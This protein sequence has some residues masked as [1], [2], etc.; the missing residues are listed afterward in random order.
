MDKE[1]ENTILK[2]IEQTRTWRKSYI[3]AFRTGLDHEVR[4]K[5]EARVTEAEINFKKSQIEREKISAEARTQREKFIT[6][7][8]QKV[9][10]FTSEVTKLL[11]DQKGKSTGGETGGN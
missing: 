2:I 9:E 11:A 7:L 4:G 5:F 3:N 6:P 10:G 8:L 1:R